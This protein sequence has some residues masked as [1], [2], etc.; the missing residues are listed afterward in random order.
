MTNYTCYLLGHK[1]T[2][3]IN[4]FEMPYEGDHRY[5]GLIPNSYH[6]CY[7]FC[8]RCHNSKLLHY[9]F[10]EDIVESMV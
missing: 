6:R 10:Y 3:L 5:K 8:R 4:V 2:K 1:Y 9:Y 7:V